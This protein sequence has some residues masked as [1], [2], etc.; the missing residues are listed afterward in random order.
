MRYFIFLLLIFT[1]IST[2]TTAQKQLSMEDAVVGQYTYLHPERL[3]SLQWLND[4]T[5]V[6]VSNDTLWSVSTQKDHPN[7]LL[8]LTELNQS[9]APTN[10]TLAQLP[11]FSIP[12]KQHIQFFARQH[13]FLYSPTKK[14]LVL[15]LE[16]P[17]EAQKTDFDF[18]TK[19]LA[20]VK[21]Q[22]LFIL[23]EEGET[24]ITFET[25]PG[26]VCGQE[27]H[28]REFGV[29][30]ANKRT[31][32]FGNVITSY[33]IHYTKLYDTFLMVIFSNV[34]LPEV[35]NSETSVLFIVRILFCLFS[36]ETTKEML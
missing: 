28:R 9:L 36:D 26:I 3:Q 11:G 13:L 25:Q 14:E 4:E 2:A 5:Y 34:F 7:V 15:D 32:A 18:N 17:K 21:G 10:I 19:Q 22:N 8:T 27:V 16:I 30:T 33:S 12:D 31:N 24:H 29:F 6:F 35:I 1:L 23:N 20:Y